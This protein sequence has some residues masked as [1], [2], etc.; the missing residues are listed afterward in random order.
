MKAEYYVE[1][2][3]ELKME[4]GEIVMETASTKHRH[5]MEFVQW[6][7]SCVGTAPGVFYQM[8]DHLKNAM[9]TVFLF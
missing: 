3:V 9:E 2:S 6:E 5:V 1:T 7:A 8:T 4:I